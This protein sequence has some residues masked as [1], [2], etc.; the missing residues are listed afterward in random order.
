MIELY[1]DGPAECLEYD[2]RAPVVARVV[3]EWILCTSFKLSRRPLKSSL[4]GEGADP[5]SEPS[6]P[7]GDIHSGGLRVEHIGSTSVPGCA[8]KG[9]IDLMVLYPVGGLEHA[10]QVLDSLGV[11]NAGDTRSVS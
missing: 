4:P 1:H 3:S 5:S 6:S 8:G 10:R 9:I 7:P 2:P 11:S